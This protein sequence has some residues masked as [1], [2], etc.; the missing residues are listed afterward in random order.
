MSKK[1]GK[2]QNNKQNKPQN[3]AQGKVQQNT[4]NPVKAEPV[5]QTGDGDAVKGKGISI[6]LTRARILGIICTVL[7]AVILIIVG[8]LLD[9]RKK[10]MSVTLLKADGSELAKI[11]KEK[12]EILFDCEVKYMSY[13][14]IVWEEAKKALGEQALMDGETQIHTCFDQKKFDTISA[15]INDV[16]TERYGNAAVCLADTHGRIYATVQKT[17]SAEDNSNYLLAGLSAGSSIKPLSVYGPAIESGQITWGSVKK[18]EPYSGAGTEDAWPVN[19]E[20]FQ[21]KDY[22]VSD[23]VKHSIN[24]IAVWVLHE[25]GTSAAVDFL[26]Q[27]FH[28]D[29][30]KEKEIA[31]EEGEDSILGNLALGG[32]RSGVTVKD[33]AGY[34]QA[35]ANGGMYQPAFSIEKIIV[36]G[37]EAYTHKGAAER[38]FSE[39]TAYICNRLLK[40]VLTEGGTGEKAAVEGLDICGKTGTSDGF[41]DNWFV[42]FTP[43]YVCACWCGNRDGRINSEK[44]QLQVFKKVMEG[45]P[46]DTRKTYPAA[47]HVKE[48]TICRKTGRE[49]GQNCKETETGYFAEG[50]MPEKCDE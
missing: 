34:Y 21:G 25:Y 43:E 27:H 30:S 16:N 47:E 3:K 5:R 46:Q 8:V 39:E 44:T 13:V 19:A 11:R 45:L 40:T 49:A 42:G 35:F 31:A 38:V 1:Q 14:G 48:V 33:M 26:E 50:H 6:G 23:A 2:K 20:D 15:A 41:M 9:G 28:M 24:T 22:L 10:D 36:D 7:A 4:G 17:E 18:D 12:D 37:K 29:L 32:L